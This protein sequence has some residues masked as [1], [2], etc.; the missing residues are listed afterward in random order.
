MAKNIYD[1]SHLRKIKQTPHLLGHLCGKTKLT[2]LHSDWIRYTWDSKVDVGLMGHRGSYKSTSVLE[3]GALYYLL[4]HPNARLFIV[5]KTYTQ[6]ASEVRTISQM[7]Q[8]DM[9]EPLFRLAWGEKWK[10]SMLRDGMFEVSAKKEKTKEPSVLALGLDSALVSLHTPD[11]IICDDFIDL[12]DRISEAERERTKMIIREIRTNIIDPGGHCILNGTPWARHD[13]WDDLEHPEDGSKGIEIRRYPVSST[14]LLTPEE[15][16]EKKSKTT[17]T[18]YAINYDLK[19]ESEEGM[20]FSDPHMGEWHDDNIEIKA[21]IDA[22]YKGDH[23]CALTIIGK[24]RNG[25]L[26][27]VGFSSPGNIKD[28][29]DF[30]IGKLIKY[31]VKELYAEDNADRGYTTDTFDMHPALQHAGIW[32]QDYHELEKKHVKIITY[33]GEAF[34]QIEFAKESSAD[35]MEQI[36]DWREGVEPDDGIDSLASIL[37]QGGYSMLALTKGWQVWDL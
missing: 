15:I 30:I 18:L 13:A 12:N 9:I 31:K 24:Q 27:V 16:A 25:R 19:F 21:H 34:K 29:T 7:M 37:C 20:L 36:V 4:F 14:G 28:W 22:A 11:V 2:Q 35:Y 6:A 26:N 8:S 3:I 5:R 32:V 33:V 10:F 1:W 23:Y 17:P